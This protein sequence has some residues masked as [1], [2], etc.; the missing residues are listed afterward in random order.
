MEVA[1]GGALVFIAGCVD[2]CLAEGADVAEVVVG[3]SDVYGCSAIDDGVDVW[4]RR[5]VCC[6]WCSDD[7]TKQLF[8]DDEDLEGFRVVMCR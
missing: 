7:S 6:L 1:Y 8:V 3:W 4:R 2:E 5:V